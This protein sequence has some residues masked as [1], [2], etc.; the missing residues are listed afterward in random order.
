MPGAYVLQA[1][2]EPQ[3]LNGNIFSKLE[4]AGDTVQV[5]LFRPTNCALRGLIAP[6]PAFTALQAFTRLKLLLGSTALDI[7]TSEGIVVVAVWPTV[8]RK[9][10]KAA[11][12]NN[13]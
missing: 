13:L 3:E 7:A 4:V 10:S 5:A 8:E 12:Q 11:N 1:V 9:P 6:P 2:L